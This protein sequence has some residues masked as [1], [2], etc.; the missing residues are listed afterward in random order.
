MAVARESSLPPV[1]L[2]PRHLRAANTR[3]FMHLPITGE[4]VPVLGGTGM[5]NIKKVEHFRAH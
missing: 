2:F 5:N 3:V 1:E 4:T